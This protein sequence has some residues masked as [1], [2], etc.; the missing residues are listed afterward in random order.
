MTHTTPHDDA[1]TI[2]DEM[3]H[4]AAQHGPTAFPAAED[5]QP[6]DVAAFARVMIT[7]RHSSRERA[8]E[9]GAD[10]RRA[11]AD[12]EVRAAPMSD[13]HVGVEI[14]SPSGHGPQIM[15]PL[16]LLA[17]VSTLREVG[18][19]PTRDQLPP[20]LVDE[21]RGLLDRIDPLANREAGQ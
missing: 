15:F 6:H 17:A 2:W 3:R 21:L 13:A 20:G 9:T 16:A 18:H 12:L 7:A 8:A 11:P 19:P 4:A 1:A 5:L 10:N 14:T